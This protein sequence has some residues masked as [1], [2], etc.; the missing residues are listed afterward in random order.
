MKL[1]TFTWPELGLLPYHVCHNMQYFVDFHIG[2]SPDSG[3]SNKTFKLIFLEFHESMQRI[4]SKEASLFQIN[5]ESNISRLAFCGRT[6]E[7]HLLNAVW[8]SVY[9]MFL[10]HC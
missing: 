7:L 9:K 6:E 2:W 4:C 3:W 5:S 1:F 10:S 8:Y